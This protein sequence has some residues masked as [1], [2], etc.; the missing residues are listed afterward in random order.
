[1]LHPAGVAVAVVLEAVARLVV[2]SVAAVEV[3]CKNHL[4]LIQ[5]V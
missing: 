1:M 5:V 3:A 4:P 2:D